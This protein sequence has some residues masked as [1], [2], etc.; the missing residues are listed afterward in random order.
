MTS[1]GMSG[2][3]CFV[4]NAFRSSSSSFH[5]F[6]KSVPF[7]HRDA[8]LACCLDFAKKL[9]GT[10]AINLEPCQPFVFMNDR[11]L[12]HHHGRLPGQFFVVEANT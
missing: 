2:V 3:F 6:D 1:D 5:L 12:P 10:S 9:T 7:L 4:S 11:Q 8:I